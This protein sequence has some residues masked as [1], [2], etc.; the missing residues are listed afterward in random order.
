MKR[1]R[2][3][4]NYSEQNIGHNP[5]YFEPFGCSAGESEISQNRQ[6][7]DGQRGECVVELG[8]VICDGVV[9]LTP[10]LQRIGWACSK[11][12]NS[13]KCVYQRAFVV[14]ESVTI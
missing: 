10:I 4:A 5:S 13:H 12:I 1:R 11:E 7:S 3:E 2:S 8:D 6:Q 14:D 9:A